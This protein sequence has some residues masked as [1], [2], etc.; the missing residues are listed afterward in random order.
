[1]GTRLEIKCWGRVYKDGVT[2][3]HSDARLP[4]NDGEKN[5]ASNVPIT[6]ALLRH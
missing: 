3:L 4:E 5:E 6:T 2:L 1:M